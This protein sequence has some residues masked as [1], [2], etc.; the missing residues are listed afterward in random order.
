[1]NKE[2]HIDFID[3]P[4]ELQPQY[5][6]F[7]EANMNKFFSIVPEFEFTP[8]EI[9]VAEYVQNYLLQENPHC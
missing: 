9:G 1:M 2:P 4:I 3:M 5:Q 6:Y 7:T 8:L